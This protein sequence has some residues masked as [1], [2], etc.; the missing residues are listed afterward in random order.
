MVVITKPTAS[1]SPPAPDDQ[2]H[3]ELMP[4][5]VCSKPQPVEGDT[6]VPCEESTRT[7]SPVLPSIAEN[8]KNAP[9]YSCGPPVLPSGLSSWQC[10]SALNQTTS[11]TN[12]NPG[13]QD[14]VVQSDAFRVSPNHGSKTNAI[15]DN[16]SNLCRHLMLNV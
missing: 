12:D 3:A 8:E 4:T 11:S 15:D 10:Y 13:Y 14:F 1:S 9:E 6:C 16:F 7:Q 5:P 2:S